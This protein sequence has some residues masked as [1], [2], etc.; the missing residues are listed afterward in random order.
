LSG[1]DAALAMHGF[2]K[3]ARYDCIF[4]NGENDG[5]PLAALFKLRRSRPAHV[6][7]GHRLTPKKKAPFLR[8]LHA[9]MDA[10]FVYAT[11]QKET[12]KRHWEFPG[13]NCI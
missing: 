10:I 5:I 11:T 9:Q 6:L 7:I 13:R 2:L 4:S 8:A 3:A 1:R 12:A